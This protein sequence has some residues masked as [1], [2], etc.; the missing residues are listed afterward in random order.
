VP[1]CC[2]SAGSASTPAPPRSQR[3][4][5]LAFAN[6]W[7]APAAAA[8]SWTFAEWAMKGVPPAWR[9][10][11]CGGGPGR[12]HPAAGFVGVGGALIIGLLSGVAGLW[13]VHGLKRLLGADDSLDV[14][15]CTGCA[16]SWVPC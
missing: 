16:G 4:G 1:P 8:L 11:R 5:G 2:G 6:T 14:S 13:G 10:L 15:A 12:H 3:H 7:I 9:C